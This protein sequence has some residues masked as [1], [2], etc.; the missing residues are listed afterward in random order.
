[1]SEDKADQASTDDTVCIDLIPETSREPRLDDMFRYV[2]DYLNNIGCDDGSRILDDILHRIRSQNRDYRPVMELQKTIDMTLQS[3]VGIKGLFTR[4]N[5]FWSDFLE[6]QSPGIAYTLPVPDRFNVSL[7]NALF[8]FLGKTEHGSC[9]GDDMILVSIVFMA[10]MGMIYKDDRGSDDPI[11]NRFDDCFQPFESG[12]PHPVLEDIRH[13]FIHN[14][15][16]ISGSEIRFVNKD[17]NFEYKVTEDEMSKVMFRIVDSIGDLPCS[18]NRSEYIH[19]LVYDVGPFLRGNSES[20]EQAY[21]RCLEMA[22]VLVVETMWTSFNELLRNMR[23]NDDLEQ[24]IG[25]YLC[26]ADVHVARNIL[27][28]EWFWGEGTRKWFL[29]DERIDMFLLRLTILSQ[30]PFVEA[31][32]LGLGEAVRHPERVVFEEA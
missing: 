15:V 2:R 12:S 26:G 31:A 17:V 4:L 27:A 29:N 1:M 21:Q 20:S 9:D 14:N 28:H 30:A 19:R 3:R 18:D 23:R 24:F 11:L 13:S 7:L 16:W 22:T 8:R 10:S 32:I 25:E 6:N 5:N